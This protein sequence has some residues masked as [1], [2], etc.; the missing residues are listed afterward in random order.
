MD[1][2]NQVSLA[3]EVEG[4]ITR[5]FSLPITELESTEGRAIISAAKV[6]GIDASNTSFQ[7]LG[8][9]KEAIFEKAAGIWKSLA[10]KSAD[11]FTRDDLKALEEV[12]GKLQALKEINGTAAPLSSEAI[13]LE[14]QLTAFIA[15][16][17]IRAIEGQDSQV[18]VNISE[19]TYAQ[20]LKEGQ[21]LSIKLHKAKPEIYK[22]NQA[23]WPERLQKWESEE[24][25]QEKGA[26]IEVVTDGCFPESSGKGMHRKG[27]EDLL[28]GKNLT[29][30]Q[31]RELAVA[32][33]ARYLLDGQSIFKGQVVRAVRAVGGALFFYAVGL[34]EFDIEDDLSDYSVSSSARLAPSESKI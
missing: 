3:K 8:K 5:I 13:P 23:I 17:G 7:D 4:E 32:H 28:A 30:E 33:T 14:Q 31:L 1:A 20:F 18:A 24:A 9:L 34:D 19:A 12:P 10:S 29:M 15:R 6:F 25:F 22:A 26:G 11:Q 21:E 16:Y 2:A 27:Q